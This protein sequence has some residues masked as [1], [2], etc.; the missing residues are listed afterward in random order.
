MV[1]VAAFVGAAQ[2]R[3]AQVQTM[4]RAAGTIEIT[5]NTQSGTNLLPG[6]SVRVASADD[7][8]IAAAVPP[9]P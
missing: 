3:A 4:T 9:A 1:M 2:G 7:H 8:T 6:V 5:V